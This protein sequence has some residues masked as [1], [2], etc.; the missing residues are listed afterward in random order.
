[1]KI[2]FVGDL[3]SYAR[4]RQRFLAMQDLGHVVQGLSSVLLE[5]ELDLD[6]KPSL[7]YL[8]SR[9]LG[10]PV[11]VVGLNEELLPTIVEF[12]PDL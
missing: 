2:L 11:D 4:A 5:T 12:Q 9:K 6:Y 3:S 8:I 10:Y 7:L 1:M